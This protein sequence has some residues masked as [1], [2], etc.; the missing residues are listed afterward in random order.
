MA[1]PN[2][3]SEA[4]N[5]TPNSEDW[6]ALRG[7]LVALLDQVEHQVST[8][9]AQG[10]GVAGLSARMRDLREQVAGAVPASRRRDAL[11]SVQKAVER[12]TDRE[13]AV[14]DPNP[15]QALQSAIDEIRSRQANRVAAAPAAAAPAFATPA[16]APVS[17]SPAAVAS[18][19]AQSEA[20]RRLAEAEKAAAEAREAL[21][22][23]QA[24]AKAFAE[25]AAAEQGRLFAG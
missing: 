23:E 24:A 16:V 8:G 18:A 11:R 13:E 22:G 7:E 19:P 10:P 12:M 6:Q 5:D 25:Q 9:Q 1:R 4:D 15:R 21:A 14:A 2:P 3:A 20:A 17:V